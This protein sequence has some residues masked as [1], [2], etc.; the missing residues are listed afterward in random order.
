MKAPAAAGAGMSD[1]ALRKA[2]YDTTLEF[3]APPSI[4]ELARAVGW[5]KTAV[6]DGLQRLATGRVVVLQPTSGELLMVPPF[7]AVP[8]PFIAR[9][10]RYRAFANCAWDAL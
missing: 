2:V 7:S 8:T 6:A 5:P 4:A 1:A 9:T 10:S 3:G